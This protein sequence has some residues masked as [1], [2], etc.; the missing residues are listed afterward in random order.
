MAYL[1]ITTGERLK[2][3]NVITVDEAQA[4]A[5]KNAEQGKGTRI[6]ST[7]HKHFL[8]VTLPKDNL[9]VRR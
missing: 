5:Q 7:D 3:V 9:N 4:I 6:F 8:V 2:E 1:I